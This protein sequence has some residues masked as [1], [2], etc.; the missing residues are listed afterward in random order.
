MKK[1]LKFKWW[2]LLLVPGFASCDD[3]KPLNLVIR[4]GS[5]VVGVMGGWPPQKVSEGVGGVIQENHLGD[6]ELVLSDE[7]FKK[8]KTAVITE[9]ETAGDVEEG[10]DKKVVLPEAGPVDEGN[11]VEKE[12]EALE[13]VSSLL[14][15]E[16]DSDGM[17]LPPLPRPEDRITPA[18]MTKPSP[19]P[20]L[21]RKRS[22]RD[23]P[24]YRVG[25]GDRITFSSFDRTD[26]DRTVTIAPD[27]TVSY[28]QAVA[29]NVN[30]LTVDEMKA[31]IEKEL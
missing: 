28:L 5:G 11:E 26:L 13:A 1:V 22:P 27:G 15:K 12:V 17:L 10:D 4:S 14:E 9:I 20:N 3:P 18:R 29:V 23:R 31:K 19:V 24:V 6:D 30:H 16:D 25:P 21:S 7:N 2:L 8:M